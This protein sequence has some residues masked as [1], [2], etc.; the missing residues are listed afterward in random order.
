MAKKCEGCQTPCRGRLCLSCRSKSRQERTD[1]AYEKRL[2]DLE[3][4]LEK[5]NAAIRESASM[6][7][8][9]VVELHN[10]FVSVNREMSLVSNTYERAVKARKKR[11]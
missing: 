8:S 9:Q 5:V 10:K 2:S 1:A 3:A 4:R 6:T 11:D 7:Y